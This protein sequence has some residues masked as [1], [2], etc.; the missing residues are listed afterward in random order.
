MPEVSHK[1]TQV[2]L[3]DIKR[4]LLNVWAVGSFLTVTLLAASIAVAETT[5]DFPRYKPSS[6]SV[7]AIDI[8]T[9]EYGASRTAPF[10]LGVGDIAPDFSVPRVGGGDI[11]LAKLASQGPVALVFY[12]GHW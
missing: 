4:D 2:L 12:R 6:R 8:R 5:E 9:N 7:E 3:H 10:A 11:S 1:S